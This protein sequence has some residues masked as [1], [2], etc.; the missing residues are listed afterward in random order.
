MDSTHA[1]VERGLGRETAAVTY[2]LAAARMELCGP[3]DALGL[4]KRWP[5]IAD[6]DRA[7]TEAFEGM[8]ES[9]RADD[10]VDVER[11]LDFAAAW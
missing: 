4:R 8:S 6:A 5:T 9:E 3:V 2:R 10:L 11:D 1:A 7:M